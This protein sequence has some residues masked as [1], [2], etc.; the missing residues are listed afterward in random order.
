[1]TSTS[2]KEHA[3]HQPRDTLDISFD[4]AEMDVRK[5]WKARVQEPLPYAPYGYTTAIINRPWDKDSGTYQDADTDYSAL[6]LKESGDTAHTVQA[7][8]AHARVD[9]R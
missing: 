8:T 3:R 2:N 1:M 7:I 5:V 9:I 4:P 6:T